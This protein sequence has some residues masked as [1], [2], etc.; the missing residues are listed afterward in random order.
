M[1]R[2]D[3]A[4]SVAAIVLF[5]AAGPAAASCYRPESSTE[6]IG[7]YLEEQAREDRLASERRWQEMNDA[8]RQA[9]RELLQPHRVDVYRG[10]Q[11][12]SCPVDVWGR[13]R[14]D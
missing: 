2:C 12:E 11:R 1:N 10:F 6:A 13:I 14:C 5:L 8:A 7:C 4:A 9:G 3:L